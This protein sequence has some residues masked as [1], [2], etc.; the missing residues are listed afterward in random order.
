MEDGR[1]R[2]NDGGEKGGRQEEQEVRRREQIG[3]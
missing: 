2:D 3:G 1:E